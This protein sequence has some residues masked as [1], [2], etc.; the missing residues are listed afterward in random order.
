ML[1][2]VTCILGCVVCHCVPL[3]HF[4]KTYLNDSGYLRLRNDNITEF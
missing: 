2:Y 3:L 4:T 1:H